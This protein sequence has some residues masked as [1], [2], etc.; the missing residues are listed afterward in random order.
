MKSLLLIVTISVAGIAHAAERAEVNI[1]YRNPEI[2]SART[3]SIRAKVSASEIINAK[4]I[5]CKTASGRTFVTVA[6]SDNGDYSI[7]ATQ[8]PPGGLEVGRVL[9]DE[10]PAEISILETFP[11]KVV[12]KSKSNSKSLL[13]FDLASMSGSVSYVKDGRRFSPKVSCKIDE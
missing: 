11:E 5:S 13:S 8:L 2:A 12:F 3:E 10:V 9:L 1:S 4:S 6:K 7:S